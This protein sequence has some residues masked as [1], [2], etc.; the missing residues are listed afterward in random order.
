MPED[1]IEPSTRM[2]DE[3][4]Q[5]IASISPD[6]DELAYLALT[7]KPEAQ[8]RDR[9][10]YRLHRQLADRD[11]I[12][13]REWKRTDLAILDRAEKPLALVEAKA[14]LSADLL[15]D[16]RIEKWHAR[17]RAD[18]DKASECAKEA[19]APDAEIY[20]LV[21]ATNVLTEVRVDQRWFVKYG[22]RLRQVTSWEDASHRLRGL[23]PRA[24]PPR[25]HSFGAGEAFGIRVEVTTWLFG[26]VKPDDL[27]TAGLSE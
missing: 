15:Y 26:P 4:V 24:A 10:A 18:I 27:R 5:A 21:I 23:L 19:H 17:V 14:L 1:N 11:V 20:A 2:R 16:R 12:V 6:P 25:E 9:L 13:A 22:V 3:L 8:I 7:S